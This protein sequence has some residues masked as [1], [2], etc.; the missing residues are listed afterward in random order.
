MKTAEQIADDIKAR[1]A[2]LASLITENKQTVAEF[3]KKIAE[4]QTKA[5]HLEG[6]IAALEGLLEPTPPAA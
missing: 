6:M 5:N 3:Q 2:E 1:Q 4:Q